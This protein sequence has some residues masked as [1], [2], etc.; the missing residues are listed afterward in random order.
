MHTHY[1][2]A[3][4]KIYLELFHLSSKSILY[5]CLFSLPLKT[6]HCPCL[7]PFSC[8]LI[9]K[10][11]QFHC[12]YFVDGYFPCRFQTSLGFG[13]QATLLQVLI[14][15]NIFG[16]FDSSAGIYHLFFSEKFIFCLPLKYFFNFCFFS[17]SFSI[18]FILSI[19]KTIWFEF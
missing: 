2:A 6:A 9:E 10:Q 11:D 13:L 17:C 5:W 7:I 18:F 8:C 16:D 19:G 3:R 12:S 4:S 1:F 14:F 15:L